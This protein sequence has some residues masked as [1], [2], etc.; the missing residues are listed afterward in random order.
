VKIL[1]ESAIDESTM[2]V[3]IKVIVRNIESRYLVRFSD[4]PVASTVHKIRDHTFRNEVNRLIYKS[5]ES[6]ALMLFVE[7]LQVE[8]NDLEMS[9][10][11]QSM[12]F[13]A[14]FSFS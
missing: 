11:S 9:K 3:T 1:R 13:Y 7:V 14:A 2:Q 8:A 12:D 5:E 6:N 4:K 10:S